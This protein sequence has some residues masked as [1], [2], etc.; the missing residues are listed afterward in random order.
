MPHLLLLPMQEEQLEHLAE[1]QGSDDDE[2]QSPV[3]TAAVGEC[4]AEGE[5]EGGLDELQEG[6][7]ALGLAEEL[8]GHLP[9]EPGAA[10]E[11]QGGRAVGPG[12]PQ[13]QGRQVSEAEAAA[14]SARLLVSLGYCLPAHLPASG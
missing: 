7:E 11:Q 8:R 4:G 6:F 3:A 9:A 2:L 13:R 5:A 10:A 14:H 12:K 1:E